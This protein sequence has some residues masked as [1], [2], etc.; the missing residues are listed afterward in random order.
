MKLKRFLLFVSVFSALVSSAAERKLLFADDFNS[1][2]AFADNWTTTGHHGKFIQAGGGCVKF[3]KCGGISYQGEMPAEFDAEVDIALYPPWAEKPGDWRGGA[4]WAGFDSDYGNFSVK[5]SGVIAMLLR[6]PGQKQTSG[7]YAAIRDYKDGEPVHLRLI[8]TKFG[9]GAKY[10][11]FVNGEFMGSYVAPFPAKKRFADGT[12]AYAPLKIGGLNVNYEVRAFRLYAV[13]HDAESPNLIYNSSF[14][15]D[16]D[17]MPTHFQYL[18]SF[19]WW[20]HPA[21]EYETRYLKRVGVDTNEF[22]SGCQ[23]LRVTLGPFLDGDFRLRPCPLATASGV[24]GVLTAWMKASKAGVDATLQYGD[25]RRDVK[26]TRDWKRY[27]VACSELPKPGI[28]GPGCILLAKPKEGEATVWIDDMQV[29]FVEVPGASEVERPRLPDLDDDPDA[30]GGFAL[31]EKPVFGF[32]PA[33]LYATPYLPSGLDA[34]RFAKKPPA[35]REPKEPVPLAPASAALRGYRLKE[36]QT[37]VLSRF[38]YFMD[39][40]E[41]RFRVWDENGKL[42]E[43]SLDIS[44]LPFGTNDVEV[45][46]HGRTWPAKIVKRPY[47]A[48]STQVDNFARCLVFDGKPF[49]FTAF[50]STVKQLR[51]PKGKQ[52][53][54]MLDFLRAKGFEYAHI[55]FWDSR[56]QVELAKA[57]LEHGQ[58][59]GMRFDAWSDE[60]FGRNTNSLI[61]ADEAWATLDVFTNI[62]ANQVID[63]PELAHPTEWGLEKLMDG[64]ARHPYWAVHMNNSGIGIANNYANHET[65]VF[66]IDNYLTNEHHGRTVNSVVSSTYEMLAAKP[67]KP[68]WYFLT[69]ESGLHY[70]NPSYGE[71]IA[72]SWGHICSGGTGISWFIGFPTTEPSWKAMVDVN[73]EIQSLVAPL[74]SAEVCGA[75]GANYG[76]R[77]L[78][79]ITR[80][81]GDDW[82]VLTCNIDAAPLDGVVFQMPPDAPQSGTVEVLFENRTLELRDS[83][84]TDSYAPHTRHLYRLSR[85]GNSN[86]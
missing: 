55:A 54:P 59:L 81:V 8:R 17:G 24:G 2:E 26:L 40:P 25:A 71:Q 43:T 74:T 21:E 22:H 18:G 44:K 80:K 16:E 57:V 20:N 53:F 86:Q 51:P 27:E 29:E 83:R 4:R 84:F 69:A 68:S 48:H 23:S 77:F 56:E 28:Q 73:R 60:E 15:Y 38:N 61:S 1:P 3:P 37:L 72:Q 75:A 11:F 14:E 35:R 47:R 49:V 79:H 32:N 67:G 13:A 78:R 45:A 50:C 64:H 76:P 5:T 42:A 10:A 39:E 9:A 12:L 7:R 52:G 36:G 63:E 31:D 34:S 65:D 19:D 70:K 58:E 6:V 33:K 46:A 41:A 82:Y 30:F 66:M 62:V 85:T